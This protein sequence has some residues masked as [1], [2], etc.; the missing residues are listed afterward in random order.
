MPCTRN[1]GQA[2]HVLPEDLTPIHRIEIPESDNWDE[3]M[4][5]EAA[6]IHVKLL[7][8]CNEDVPANLR[9]IAEGNKLGAPVS[10]FE[11][12]TLCA[13]LRECGG[14]SYTASL[15]MGHPTS[16]DA[17]D[18]HKWAVMHERNDEQK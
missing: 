13:I 12:Q 11:V 16:I 7:T 15:V 1:M 8:L 17:V 18:V 2:N 14:S 3:S 5:R 10:K 4:H 9:R 6:Q